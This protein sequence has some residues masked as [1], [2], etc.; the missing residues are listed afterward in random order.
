MRILSKLGLGVVVLAA[1]QVFAGP[2][3]GATFTTTANGDRVNA[4][5]YS[6]KTDVYLD[7]GPGANA[8]AGAAAL[9]AGWY[10]FQVTDPAGKVLLSLDP[11]GS[12][13]FHVN[14]QGLVDQ[15]GTHATGLDQDHGSLTVQLWPFAD[16]PN[17]GGEYKVWITPVSQHRV[18]SGA[19][20][21]VGKFSK[22]D[23][24]KVRRPACGCN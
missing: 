15:V 7:G 4:N 12:R 22:T 1:A 3:A 17:N 14:A 24:F 10:F 9:D 11:V 16:T 21:F 18:G 2:P 6:A 13:R 20:G 5:L 23:N 19:F 8:P